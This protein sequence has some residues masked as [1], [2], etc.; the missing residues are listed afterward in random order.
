MRPLLLLPFLATGL[1]AAGCGGDDAPETA[2]P[3]KLA[4]TFTEA[5]G[6][7]LQRRDAGDRYSTLR[8]EDRAA[9]GRFG[10]FTLYVVSDEETRERM[11]STG[12]DIEDLGQGVLLSATGSDG[13]KRRRLLAAVKASIAGNPRA[14]PASDRTCE[15]AGIDPARGETGTCW[16]ADKQVTVV[17]GAAPLRTKAID[18]RLLSATTASQLPAQSQYLD[19]KVAKGKYVVVRF[20]VTNKLTAALNSVRP[21]LVVDGNTYEESADS[22]ALTDYRDRPYPLQ[23][24]DHA[25]ITVAFDVPPAVADKALTAGALE[26]PAT[27]Y[28]GSTSLSDREAVGRI[29]LAGVEPLTLR[30]AGGRTSTQLGAIQARKTAAEGALKE[31]YRAL[32]KGNVRYVC[33]RLTRATQQRFGGASAC[34]NGRFV[35]AQARRAAP[36]TTAGLDFTTV[37]TQR[38][39][40]ALVLVRRK[41]GGG[42]TDSARLVR[43]DGLWRVQATRRLAAATAGGG[44]G[45]R[46]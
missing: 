35:K 16:L 13:E 40:Q 30:G 31:F 10:V 33:K 4:A 11:T 25:A 38:S 46:A 19:P 17:D 37:L 22:Y 28:E 23:P 43:Q 21:N 9:Y 29:R 26:L 41:A 1:L 20:D 6:V 18:A 3:T 2:D 7:G 42:F 36:T 34:A 12:V 5:T 32:R 24:Q 39:T 44:A 45:T 8:T 15:A 27:T 14:L